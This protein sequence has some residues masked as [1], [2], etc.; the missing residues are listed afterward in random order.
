MI[1][2]GEPT[3]G[4][5]AMYENVGSKLLSGC[6]RRFDI[7]NRS[8]RITFMADIIKGSVKE[9]KWCFKS[10]QNPDQY[11]DETVEGTKYTTDFVLAVSDAN[12]Q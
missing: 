12:L 8:S 6:G 10:L 5:I 9:V 3:I 11:Y 2:L 1:E 4:G 7:F